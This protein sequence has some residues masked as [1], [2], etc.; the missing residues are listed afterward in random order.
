VIYKRQQRNDAVFSYGAMISD[1][2]SKTAMNISN[3]QFLQLL[4]LMLEQI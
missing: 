4:E 2:F 1:G 3:V